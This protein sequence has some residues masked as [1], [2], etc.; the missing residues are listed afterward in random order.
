MKGA[1]WKG[2]KCV[3]DELIWFV[4]NPAK[5]LGECN[6]LIVCERVMLTFFN[7]RK[8]K[9]SYQFESKIKICQK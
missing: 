3:S 9:K 2:N 6:Q 7:Y 8:F 4:Q 5:I 1:T